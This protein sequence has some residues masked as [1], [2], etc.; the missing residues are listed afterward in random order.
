MYLRYLKT[1][2]RFNELTINAFVT[3]SRILCMQCITNILTLMHLIEMRFM[4]LHD[5]IKATDDAMKMFFMEVYE[6]FIKVLF[7]ICIMCDINHLHRSIKCVGVSAKTSYIVH[8]KIHL[9]VYQLITK[10]LRTVA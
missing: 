2:D 8:T 6:L 5:N 9:V 4:L 1:V 10:Y 7:V 3:A